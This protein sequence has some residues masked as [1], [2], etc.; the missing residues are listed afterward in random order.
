[1]YEYIRVYMNYM[2]IY[3]FVCSE[4]IDKNNVLYQMCHS[5]LVVRVL[6]LNPE[7]SGSN[8]LY[9]GQISSYYIK[10]NLVNT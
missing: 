10:S 8:L 1:M 2:S 5:S 4:Y 9:G 7:F 3:E 6:D